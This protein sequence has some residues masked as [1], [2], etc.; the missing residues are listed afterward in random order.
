M[1]NMIDDLVTLIEKIKSNSY[2]S[3]Y[4]EDQTKNGIILPIL[5]RLGWDT[6]NIDEV[7]PEFSIENQR[8]DYALRL[9]NKQVV[10]LEA[11][12]PTEDL[13]N[14]G[15]Q[16]QLLKYSYK[17]SV[18]LAVFTNGITWY[19]YLP[20][21]G[22]DWKS[23]KFSTVDLKAQ[24]SVSVANKLIELLSKK[25]IESGEALHTAKAIHQDKMKEGAIQDAIPVAWNK[26]IEEPDSLLLELLAENTEKICGHRPETSTLIKF[27]KSHQPR[28]LTYILNQKTVSEPRKSA[29][30]FTKP[31]NIDTKLPKPRGQSI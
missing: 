22:V 14:E 25:N 7:F 8:V 26:I 28:I 11:K 1:N 4:N 24:E 9:K 15:H 5:R 20:T 16:D 17:V 29:T 30:I 31:V 27:L 23:R 12:R 10:F 2:V 21:A 19:L 13:D 6:E 3:S 18:E